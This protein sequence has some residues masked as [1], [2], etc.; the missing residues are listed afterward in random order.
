MVLVA[1]GLALKQRILSDKVQPFPGHHQNR[2]VIGANW[3]LKDYFSGFSSVVAIF[4]KK[5][6]R[7]D[8]KFV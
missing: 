6:G 4:Y 2:V 5:T 7:G 1:I 3:P 8:A